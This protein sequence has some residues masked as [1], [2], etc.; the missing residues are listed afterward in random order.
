MAAQ[1]RSRS[2]QGQIRSSHVNSGS[3]GTS[4]GQLWCVQL[5]LR[6][7]K[8][9]ATVRTRQY[10]A[11]VV[12]IRSMSKSGQVRLGKDKVLSGQFRT[13]RSYQ[14]MLIQCHIRL[15]NGR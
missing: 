8:A 12:R 9:K 2:R 13:V 5:Q 14:V 11:G 15:D 1:V 4:P 7:C 10:L 3:S 6:H